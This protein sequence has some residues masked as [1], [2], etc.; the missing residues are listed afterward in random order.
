M[1]IL[2][3]YLKDCDENTLKFFLDGR[4]EIENLKKFDLAREGHVTLLELLISKKFSSIT[5]KV[6]T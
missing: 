4:K 5:I 2:S 1:S 6:N 3:G